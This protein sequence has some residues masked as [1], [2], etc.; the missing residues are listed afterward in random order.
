MAGA[1]ASVL[2]VQASLSK[3]FLSAS[4]Q[5]IAAK[6]PPYAPITSGPRA[7]CYLPLKSFCKVDIR[8][9]LASIDCCIETSGNSSC[10]KCQATDHIPRQLLQQ[11][12]GEGPGA[13]PAAGAK[14]RIATN[15]V[16]PWMRSDHFFNSFFIF[17]K[18]ALAPATYGSSVSF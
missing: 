12:Q 13:T 5:G 1:D 4:H 7:S 16:R 2:P 15:A 11:Q 10:N 6:T 3:F 14:G 17:S 18:P 8:A 9:S